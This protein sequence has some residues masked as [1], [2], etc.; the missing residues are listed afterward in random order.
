MAK[1]HQ[2]RLLGAFAGL[3]CCA[4][5]MGQSSDLMVTATIRDFSDQ[6][7]DFGK[8][9]VVGTNWVEKTLSLQLDANGL[10]SYVPTGKRI[11]MSAQD[12]AGHVIASALIQATQLI[13]VDGVKVVQVPNVTGTAFIDAYDPSAGPYGG[14][15]VVT[16]VTAMTG[17]TM[18][19][20]VEPA[21]ST[22][23]AAVSYS[24]DLSSTLSSSFRCGTFRVENG[25]K[26]TIVGDVTIVSD[27]EFRI[28]NMGNVILAPG[29]TLKVYAKGIC[30]FDNGGVINGNTADHTRFQLYRIGMGDLVIRNGANLTGQVIAPNARVYMPNTGTIYGQVS[31]ARLAMANASAIHVAHIPQTPCGIAVH[32]KAAQ[33]G[34]ADLAGISSAATFKQWFRDVAGVNQ[35]IQARMRFTQNASGTWEFTD[36]DFRPID[37]QLLSAGQYG[38]NR[39]FTL[40]LDGQFEFV[41]CSGQYF[42]FT[43]AGDAMAF[44]DN[45]LVLELMGNNAGM[46]QYVD[47]DR[48]GLN[49]DEKH[50]FKFF[51]AQRSGSGAG[52]E[53]GMRTNVTLDTTYNVVSPALACFD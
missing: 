8:P 13:P 37:G 44:V 21:L 15:N 17:Q 4:G 49:P 34:A 46:G 3:A 52:A 30:E 10:P 14:S 36:S 31:A 50:T 16:G 9:L 53:F 27:V 28:R 48:L 43:G 2:G 40:A 38:A 7:P 35:G 39:Y 1:G 20:V 19:T 11:V 45:K 22:Y 23:N 26:L 32:D 5:A 24:G 25:Y 6:H 51:Y 12:A 42:T 41:S 33:F 29:A 18:P 47:F